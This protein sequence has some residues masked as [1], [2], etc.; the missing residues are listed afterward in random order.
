MKTTKQ[1]A[2]RND[3]LRTTGKGGRMVVS[4]FLAAD[5][6][7]DQVIAAMRNFDKFDKENDPHGEHDCGI[8]DVDGESYLFKIDYYTPDMESGADPKS[9]PAV[10]VLTVMLASDY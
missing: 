1:I 9:E 4:G 5:P 8:F 6:K 10:H 3:L 7:L 2:E